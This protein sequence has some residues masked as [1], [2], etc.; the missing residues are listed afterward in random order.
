MMCLPHGLLAHMACAV[1]TP[2]T[3][4]LGAKNYINCTVFDSFNYFFI[5]P[6][7]IYVIKTIKSNVILLI[8]PK[9]Y[10]VSLKT[11]LEQLYYYICIYSRYISNQSSHN[12]TR[13]V[14]RRRQDAGRSDNSIYYLLY[15]SMKCWVIATK[16]FK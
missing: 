15:L 8:S 3:S 14:L 4:P 10:K 9:W 16:L 12:T 1:H 7:C 2:F 5:F 11:T 13:A 6:F